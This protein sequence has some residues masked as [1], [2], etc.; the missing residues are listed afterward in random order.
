MRSTK[1]INVKSIVEE[2]KKCV[3]NICRPVA[4]ILQAGYHK[5]IEKKSPTSP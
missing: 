5:K 2:A 4:I 1:K 3:D